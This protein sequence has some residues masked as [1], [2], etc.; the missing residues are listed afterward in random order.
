MDIGEVRAVESEEKVATM[1]R[2]G[3]KLWQSHMVERGSV[4]YIMV[5]PPP[6]EE[7]AGG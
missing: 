4:T 3:W 5:A 2:D 6:E 7:L 1:L